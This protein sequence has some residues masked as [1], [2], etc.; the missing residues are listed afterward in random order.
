VGQC[1]STLRMRVE[2]AFAIRP[3]GA[4]SLHPQALLKVRVTSI[5]AASRVNSY[6][7]NIVGCGRPYDP[8][9]DRNEIGCAVVG[10][11]G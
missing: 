2:G 1:E 6:L 4:L 10:N 3:K 9:E 7:D 8:D 11:Y 5:G